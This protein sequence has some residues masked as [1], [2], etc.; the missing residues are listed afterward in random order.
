M[1]D[2]RE[3]YFKE[4]LAY[5]EKMRTNIGDERTEKLISYFNY[6][7]SEIDKFPNFDEKC[8][9]VVKQTIK[10]RL[11][12][13]M[14]I[15]A[16]EDPKQRLAALISIHGLVGFK[17]KKPNSIKAIRDVSKDMGMSVGE[18]IVFAA[19]YAMDM[20]K[21]EEEPNSGRNPSF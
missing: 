16:I 14:R 4:R 10:D 20:I 6:L 8:L 17:Y 12:T 5:A 13:E 11:V 9:E 1:D 15:S 2:V 3:T 7:K 19:K 18:Y 21:A